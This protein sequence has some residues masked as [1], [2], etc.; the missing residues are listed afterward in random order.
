MAMTWGTIIAGVGVVFGLPALVV[1]L[2]RRKSGL[3]W[4]AL[5]ALVGLLIVG[6]LIEAVMTK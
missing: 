2:N 1:L 6:N 5:C 3:G 4:I